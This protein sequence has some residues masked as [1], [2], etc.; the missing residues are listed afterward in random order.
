MMSRKMIVLL[1]VLVIVAAATYVGFLWFGGKTRAID[2]ILRK[3]EFT[4]LDPPSTLAPPG[5]LVVV[6][7][8]HPLV[9]GVICGSSEALGDKLTDA[10]LSSGSSSSKEAEEL[11]GSF[12]LGA[13][14][15]TRLAGEADSKFV[16][17]I[18]LTLS[19]VK[20]LELPDSAVFQLIG[21]RKD[22]CVKALEFRQKRNSK[23]SMIKAVIQANVVYQIDFE[24]NLDTSAKAQIRER[25][26]GNLGLKIRDQS[27][28]TIQGN[29]LHWGV[30]DD[31]SLATI[32]LTH[33]P[34]TGAHVRPRV[35]PVDR[36]AAVIR[37][38]EEDK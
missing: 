27:Q 4:E 38:S 31:E 1:A 25:I 35:L 33:P 26:A 21:N 37:E 14:N 23:V 36:S 3:Y 6:N 8:E 10:V 17:R 24:G 5:T 30:R 2:Q 28:D 32:S 7:K 15:K 20:L 34:V 13:E 18:T 11:T 16:K 9:I 22:S 29:G 19:D 12:R